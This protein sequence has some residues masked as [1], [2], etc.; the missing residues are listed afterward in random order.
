MMKVE[1]APV[2][3]ARLEEIA[4][5]HRDVTPDEKEKLCGQFSLDAPEI[6]AKLRELFAK[7]QSAL[8]H[9]RLT[10]LSE[11]LAKVKPKIEAL[12]VT[13]LPR[14]SLPSDPSDELMKKVLEM[15]KAEA[16]FSVPP[17]QPRA[18]ESKVTTAFVSSM[19]DRPFKEVRPPYSRPIPEAPIA[20]PNAGI[21]R[22]TYPRGLL[23]HATQYVQDTAALPN[24][25]LSMAT[26]LSALGKGLDRKVLGPGDSGNSVILWMLLIAETGAGKQHA[27]NCIRMLLRAMGAETAIVA[28]GLGSVQGIEEILE[29]TT[30]FD[31]NPSP[32][33]VIDEVGGWLSRI[34]SKGQTGN[35]SE[36]PGL[37]QSLWGWPPQLEWLG[38]KTKGKEMKPVHG[39]AFS[40]FGASTEKKL[41]RALT[42]DQVENG[43][44]NRMLLVNVGRGALERIEPK[45]EWSKFPKWLGDALKAVAGAP[46]PEGAMRLETVDGAVLRDFRRIGWGSG[47]KELWMNFEKDIRGMPSIEDREL[48]IRAPEQ[49]LRLATVVAA[50]R[51]SSLV[52]VE[53]WQWAEEVVKHSMHQLVQA[54]H[55][56]LSED[57]DQ[58]DLVDRIRAEFQKKARKG[59][60]QGQLTQ[61]QI[62]KLCERMTKDHRKIDQAIDHLV[63]CGDIV[64]LNQEGKVGK[65][66]R[67]WQWQG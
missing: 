44:V 22:L 58:A 41:I 39:P 37:L 51:R 27:I 50:Y 9:A 45:Y 55:R 10:N 2:M 28:S 48:W 35:V 29:G 30:K 3:L 67:K 16:S 25:W 13:A 33:V 1:I 60:A 14:R 18:V 49:A 64:P 61:G 6:G 66:T 15:K 52:E 26:A 8:D 36:I 53:D 31:P 4:E 57:L 40:M 20:P 11:R 63:K 7:Q 24:R 54:M 17:V 32:L 21:D 34:S 43:F 46:A 5:Q 47:A 38:S 12:K 23:G 59:E 19:L 62:S 65:P 42:K 56:N